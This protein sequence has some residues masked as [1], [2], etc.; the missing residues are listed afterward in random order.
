MVSGQ[1]RTFGQVDS[2]V[3]ENDTPMSFD[4]QIE[5]PPSFL[6]M[7]VTPGRDRPNAQQ[8]VVLARYELCED[9]ACMLTEHAQKIAFVEDI[10]EQKVLLRCHEGLRAD[11]SNLDEKESVWV[12]HRLAE[13]LGWPPPVFES[14]A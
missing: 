5:P 6:A 7:Y 4:N 1:R 9:L 2:G 14:S 13:L 10:A 8:E 12:I 3:L 11:P